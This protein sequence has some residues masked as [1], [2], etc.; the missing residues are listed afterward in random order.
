M[1]ISKNEIYYLSY[2]AKDF[3]KNQYEPPTTNIENKKVDIAENFEHGMNQAIEIL[4]TD[5]FVILK[6]DLK[7]SESLLFDISNYFGSMV[8]Q[9]PVKGSTTYSIESTR[10]NLTST[11]SNTYQ[12]LH[13]DGNF[14]PTPPKIIALQCIEPSTQGGYSKIAKADDIYKYIEKLSPATLEKLFDPEAL[15]F[16]RKDRNV[17]KINVVEYKKPIFYY[18]ENGNMGIS[19]NP[20][21]AKIESTKEIETAFKL[22]S[23]F[24]SKPKNQITFKL[25]KGETLIL[26]NYAVLH[27]RTEFPAD[28]GRHL[29]RAWYDGNGSTKLSLGFK[30]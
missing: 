27:A 22:I 23:Y 4:N 18:L 5:G 3:E 26:D 9:T 11:K 25:E 30:V 17:E 7:K 8:E 15:T 2:L 14:K 1:T 19:L 10:A 21:M 16:Y 28:Q 13:S 24:T 6:S 12:P 29:K 20:M